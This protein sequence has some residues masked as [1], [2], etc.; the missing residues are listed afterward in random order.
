[1]LNYRSFIILDSSIVKEVE[2]S[3]KQSM[4]FAKCQPTDPDSDL[5]R[6][7]ERK[8]FRLGLVR[9]SKVPGIN[10][11]SEVIRA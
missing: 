10:E 1:M 11:Q 7:T 5:S 6:V 9:H 4:L 8:N 3:K 2:N